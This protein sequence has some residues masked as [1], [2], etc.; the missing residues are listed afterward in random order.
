[1]GYASIVGG[2]IGGQIPSDESTILIDPGNTLYIAS[3]FVL[4]SFTYR[5]TA[6]EVS[7]GAG[8]VLGQNRSGGVTGTV[9]IRGPL[10]WS[11]ALWLQR[12]RL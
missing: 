10:D 5:T 9:Y 1:M 12:H 8:L 7:A 4:S 3:A 6:I 11:P 2:Y